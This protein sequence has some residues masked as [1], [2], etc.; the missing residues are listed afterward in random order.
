MKCPYI[1]KL[2]QISQSRYEHDEEG[3]VKFF[4]ERLIQTITHTECLRDECMAFIDG[5]CEYR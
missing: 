4:E 1:T 3:E 5:K 2:E